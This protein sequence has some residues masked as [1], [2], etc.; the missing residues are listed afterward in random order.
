MFYI[1][2]F[3]IRFIWGKT[4]SSATKKFKSLDYATIM[5]HSGL[6]AGHSTKCFVVLQ[7]PEIASLI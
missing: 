2:G 5:K 6:M 7:Q 4:T 1:L 3:F